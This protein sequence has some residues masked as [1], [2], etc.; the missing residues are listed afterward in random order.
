MFNNSRGNKL[1]VVCPLIGMLY[2]MKRE[3]PK[4]LAT[5][6]WLR[7]NSEGQK[8]GINDSTLCTLCEVRK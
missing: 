6:V 5:R 2:T 8:P 3:L 7:Q 1:V 4:V